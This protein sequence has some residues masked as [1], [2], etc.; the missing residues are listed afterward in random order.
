MIGDYYH[1]RLVRFSNKLVYGKDKNG[2][3]IKIIK[4]SH[5]HMK[6]VY[7]IPK[8]IFESNNKLLKRRTWNSH[9][10]YNKLQ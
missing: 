1:Y 5:C 8:E 9:I 7:S 4:K 6:R 3:K 2:F 10:K